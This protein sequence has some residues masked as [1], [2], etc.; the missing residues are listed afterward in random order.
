MRCRLTIDNPSKPSYHRLGNGQGL[1]I[2][3]TAASQPCSYTKAQ[4]AANNCPICINQRDLK[5]SGLTISTGYNSVTSLHLSLQTS[6][7]SK[8]TARFTFAS[9]QT[10]RAISIPHFLYSFIFP[11]SIHTSTYPPHSN[12]LIRRQKISVMASWVCHE[13]ESQLGQPD[14]DTVSHQKRIQR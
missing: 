9:H 7:N 6:H 2:S 8:S 10:P 11:I 13:V 5:H 1:G 3:I 4:E 14:D 12:H